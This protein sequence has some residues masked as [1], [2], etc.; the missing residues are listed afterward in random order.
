M[1]NI[2]KT[3]FSDGRFIVISR[4]GDGGSAAVWRVVDTMYDVERAIK[5]LHLTDGE[6]SLVRFQQEVQ[7]MMRLNSANIVTVYESFVED[8]QLHVVMEKCTGS[9]NSWSQMY[10]HMPPRLAVKVVIEMLKGLEKAHRIGV[11][12]RDI[13]PHNVLIDEDGGVKIADFGLAL[14]YLSP[15]SLTKTGALLGSLAFMSPE[16][17]LNPTEVDPATDIYST[18]MTLAWLLENKSVSDL[19]L[20]ETIADLRTRYPDALV[21]VIERG[22][23]HKTTDRFT[24]A[25]EM[26]QA[27]KQV[28]MELPESEHSLM[29]LQ[30]VEVSVEDLGKVNT[31]SQVV[32]AATVEMDMLH[33]LRWMML[34]V[35]G[36]LLVVMGGV[37][38]VQFLKAPAVSVVPADDGFADIPMCEDA[39]TSFAK[40]FKPGPRE[41]QASRFFDLNRDGRQDALFINQLDQ[42][43]S[44]Y[45][46]NEAGKFDE[47]AEFAYPRSRNRPLFGDLNNDGQLDM[48]SLHVDLQN[49]QVHYSNPDGTWIAPSEETETIL[50]QVYPPLEGLL[51]D[52]NNDGQLDLYFTS[53]APNNEETPISLRLGD[54]KEHFLGHEVL[55]TVP[56]WSALS[57]TYPRLYWMDGGSLYR[58]DLVKQTAPSETLAT[59]LPPLR[60]R[61]VVTSPS[62]EEQAVLT[63]E[64][65]HVFRWTETM[66]LCQLSEQGIGTDSLQYGPSFG[67]WDDNEVLDVLAIRT[68]AYCTSNHLLM[69]GNR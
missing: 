36:L 51:Y 41:A 66:G 55:F 4:L 5:T 39:I 38:Y 13:K 1:P 9:L 43:M 57:D 26:M 23:K 32:T 7:I 33:S 65:A 46:G 8:G 62:G 11:V 28:E 52:G 30:L 3:T 35:V 47:P 53:Q 2:P 59:D 58:K 44:V 56:D 18:T 31:N 27:L 45:W 61:Q 34:V 25:K 63:D 29:G 17:R 40:S 15:E 54:P 60:I 16:Q 10:G 21:D 42:N 12:H 19:Y 64:R 22:G 67:F 50:F 24:S 49:I 20:S 48:V 14:F 68:C 6:N 69:V 37:F